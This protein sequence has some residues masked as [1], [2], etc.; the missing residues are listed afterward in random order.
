MEPLS[1]LKHGAP[2]LNVITVWHGRRF[3]GSR[4]A[5]QNSGLVITCYRKIFVVAVIF[6]L[7]IGVVC[8]GTNENIKLSGETPMWWDKLW[9]KNTK[10]REPSTIT[11]EELVTLVQESKDALTLL[12]VR[13][14][15]EYRKGHIK[16]SQ[17]IPLGELSK[18]SHELPS[19]HLI[20]TVCRSGRRAAQATRI[21][22]SA[23][24][25]RV[26]TLEGGVEKW[27]GRIV[28]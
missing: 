14:L 19:G 8:R 3:T 28:K 21:L 4:E 18:R 9:N 13:E 25:D 15:Q 20:V 23:G 12:D 22:R 17:L 7:M 1:D 27:P 26:R 10:Q 24:F 6:L 16:G 2:S 5:N 11:G